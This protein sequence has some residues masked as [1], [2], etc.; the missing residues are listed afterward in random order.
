MLNMLLVCM[1]IHQQHNFGLVN[2]IYNSKNIGEIIR[3]SLVKCE[4][5]FGNEKND[6]SRNSMKTNGAPS[7]ASFLSMYIFNKKRDEKRVD[8]RCF[9]T[10]VT[11]LTGIK[12]S[13][14]LLVLG[15]NIFLPSGFINRRY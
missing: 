5:E 10:K 7:Y 11:G 13:D 6:R 15:P 8:D 14:N 12:L 3:N 2:L 4:F 1:R 9:S